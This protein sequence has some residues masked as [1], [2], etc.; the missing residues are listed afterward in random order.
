[1]MKS[2]SD[3]TGEVGAVLEPKPRLRLIVVHSPDVAALSRAWGDGVVGRD[4]LSDHAVG[5]DKMSRQ[6]A[7][8]SFD[9]TALMDLGSRNGT[10]VNARRVDGAGAL[11]IGDVVRVGDTL[12]VVDVEIDKD[13]SKVTEITGSSR[14]SARLR[15]IVARYAG[16]DLSVCIM[17][18]TGTGK[19]QLAKAFH[20]MSG[21]MG[22]FV[23]VNCGGITS[24]LAQSELFGHKRGAFTGAVA[25][26][27]GSIATADGGTLF[28][29][30]LGDL[31]RPE[32]ALLLRVLQDREVVPVG[33]TTA[34]KI[35]FRLVCA[36]NVNLPSAVQEGRFRDDLYHRINALPVETTPLRERRADILALYY[37]FGGP[38][39][40]TEAAQALLLR[41]WPAN[42][43]G[44]QTDARRLKIEASDGVVSLALLKE[45]GME[46]RSRPESRGPPERATELIERPELT[47]AALQAAL[48]QSEGNR[49]EA[50]RRLG[51]S[52]ATFY[53]HLP[54]P[55][56]GG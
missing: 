36:T 25:D 45:L 27:S 20:R 15:D 14:A 42:A 55:D 39:L 54:K 38:T 34:K 19:E 49:T 6:H 51:V 37:H 13:S 33:S 10:W 1:M 31:P 26:R 2:T 40:T 18:P 7:R 4:P 29:D 47:P 48:E 44:V 56:A 35:D 9:G 17:G 43:R 30:E 41:T 3:S 5:D 50:A 46:E 11:D 21:R 53:R 24:S 16:A 52:R 8:I 28:L 32:Q 12:A 23:A 22:R